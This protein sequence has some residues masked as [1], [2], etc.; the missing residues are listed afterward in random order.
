MSREKFFND[1][2]YPSEKRRGVPTDW[3]PKYF[4]TVYGGEDWI[5]K[6][7]WVEENITGIWR[8][9]IVQPNYTVGFENEADAFAFKLTWI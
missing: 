3:Q 2:L 7:E 9:N 6:S 5:Q 8:D 4:V 1:W